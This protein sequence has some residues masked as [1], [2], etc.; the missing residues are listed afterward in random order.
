MAIHTHE[1]CREALRNKTNPMEANPARRPSWVSSACPSS[2]GRHP[3]PRRRARSANHRYHPKTLADTN[4]LAEAFATQHDHG[5]AERAQHASELK[6]ARHRTASLNAKM[7]RY[8]TDYASGELPAR[9]FT[10]R[11]DE[12]LA[13]KAAVKLRIPTPEVAVT[14]LVSRPTPDTTKEPAPAGAGSSNGPVCVYRPVGWRWRE[15][16]LAEGE[17]L[18]IP[19][20]TTRR[21]PQDCGVLR[22]VEV[23]RNFGVSPWEEYH[24]SVTLSSFYEAVKC[25]PTLHPVVSLIGAV[26]VHFTD[27]SGVGV[28]LTRRAVIG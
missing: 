28:G 25:L 6:A 19:D 10:A 11:H 21:T 8:I 20:N 24:P 26:A 9:L 7:A 3:G 4:L 5:T 16:S 14:L 18:P 2:S 13:Q 15:P 17:L 12:L 1:H 27:S 23:T 22:V